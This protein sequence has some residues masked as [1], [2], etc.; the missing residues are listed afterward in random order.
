MF[1]DKYNLRDV[2][3]YNQMLIKQTP[4]R[5]IYKNE[6]AALNKGTEVFSTHHL[7]VFLLTSPSSRPNSAVVLLGAVRPKPLKLAVSRMFA[8][9]LKGL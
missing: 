6:R 9:T 4:T 7:R 8:K 5:S 2:L 1:A 3:L